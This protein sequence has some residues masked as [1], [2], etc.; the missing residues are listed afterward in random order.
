MMGKGRIAV[1]AGGKLGLNSSVTDFHAFTPVLQ[2]LMGIR[3]GMRKQEVLDVVS[4]FKHPK[5]GAAGAGWRVV[6]ADG[7]DASPGTTQWT[8][9]RW[10]GSCPSWGPC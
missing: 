6:G 5:T 2:S 7:A 8:W 3:P 4:K 10:R 9:T 1:C